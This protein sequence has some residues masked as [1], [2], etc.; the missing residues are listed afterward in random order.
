MTQQEEKWNIEAFTRNI[1]VHEI[2]FIVLVALCF[3][4]D[5]LG[6]ISDRSVIFYWLIMAPVFFVS[7]LISERA[8]QHKTGQTVAH[9]IKLEAIFWGSAFIS[10]ILVLFLWHAGSLKAETTGLVIHIILAHTMFLS[11]TLL[12]MRFYLIGMFLFIL[13]GLAITMS[14]KVGIAFFISIPVLA[15]GLYYEKHFLFPSLKRTH[16]KA[17]WGND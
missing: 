14:G 4:G 11:G 15:I 7:S 17:Y 1:Y 9:F 16:D 13:A 5:V 3:L 8:T 6:E 12:G 10:V 2:I